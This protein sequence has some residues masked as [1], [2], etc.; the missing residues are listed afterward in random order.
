LR[1]SEL[2]RAVM[3]EGRRQV[4]MT[5]ADVYFAWNAIR[6]ADGYAVYL[7]AARREMIDAL[8]AAVAA[9]GLQVERMDLK[10]LALARGMGVADGLLLEWGAAEATL[11]LMARG[12]P[13]FFRTF[14]LDAPADDVEAQLD[15]LALS[16]NALIKFIRGSASDVPITPATPL[17]LGGRFSF[18]PDG[19]QRAEQRFDFRVTL[20][21]TRF[22]APPGFPWEA[23]FAGAGLIQQ[24]R[25]RN[26]LTPSQGGDTRVAA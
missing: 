16:L 23:H 19:P 24:S 11:V 9:A 12:R 5:A 20:P 1:D 8:I 22:T 17:F 25:W 26:R 10:P 21:T 15:E 7:A 2:S 4:P 14:L 3:F 18:L 6:D 13:R